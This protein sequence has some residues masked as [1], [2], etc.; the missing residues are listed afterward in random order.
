MHIIK[1]GRKNIKRVGEKI[2]AQLLITSKILLP[3]D[4][5]LSRGAVNKLYSYM[6]T[7]PTSS[8]CQ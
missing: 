8:T 7:K 3:T 6:A 1:D 4:L 2:R 5:L